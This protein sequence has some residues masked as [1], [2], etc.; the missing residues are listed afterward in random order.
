MLGS[1]AFH[2]EI[3]GGP[4]FPYAWDQLDG[5]GGQGGMAAMKV[6]RRP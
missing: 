3:S 4:H 5:T 6:V 2:L 1:L